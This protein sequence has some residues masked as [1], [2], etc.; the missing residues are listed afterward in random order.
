[1]EVK[2]GFLIVVRGCCALRRSVAE[3]LCCCSRDEE[4]EFYEMTSL[5]TRQ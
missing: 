4:E 5:P 3:C 1:M 2:V